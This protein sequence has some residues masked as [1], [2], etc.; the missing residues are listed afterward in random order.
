MLPES[1]NPPNLLVLVEMVGSSIAGVI[2]SFGPSLDIAAR[3]Q[4]LKKKPVY[5]PT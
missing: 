5:S 4:L 2:D 1:S 3:A